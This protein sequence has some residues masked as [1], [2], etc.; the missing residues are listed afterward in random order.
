MKYANEQMSNEPMT[1]I[2]YPISGPQSSAVTVERAAYVAIGLLAAALRFFQLGVRPLNGAEAVQALAALHFTQG[3]SASVPTGTIPALFSGNVVGFTL[4]GADD[5][6]ARLLPA[7]AGLVLVLL[8]YSLRGR[9]GRGGALAASLLL[10]VSPSAVYLSRCLDGAILVA[11][12]GLAL[13]VGLINFLDT[14]RPA[15]FY[16][17]AGAL[18]LGLCAGPAFYTLVLTFVAFVP[19]LYLAEKLLDGESGWPALL[20]AW[21]AI[22]EEKGLLATAAA[23]AAAAFGL[24]ATTFILHPAGVGQAA[25]LLGAWAQSF[26]PEPGGQPA[27]YLLLLLLL[28]EPLIL[29]LGAVEAG[30]AVVARRSPQWPGQTA[31][32]SFP[33]TAFFAFWGGL[34]FLVILVSGH[35]PAGNVLLVVVPLALLAGQGAERAWRWIDRRALWPEVGA[36]AA[37]A[38]G[39][40]IFFYLQIASYSLTP[41]AATVTYGGITFYTSTT[42]LLLASLALALLVVLG[43]VA[44]AWRG[45]VLVA[46]GGWLALVF[47]LLLVAFKATWGLNMAHAADPRELMIARGTAADVRTLVSA[48]ETLSTDQ[49]SDAHTLPITVDAATGPV[50]AWYLRDFQKQTVVED[51]STPPATVAALTL[52]RRD[53]PIGETY[54]G[55]GF[56]LSVHWSPW[57]LWGQKL[58]CWLL[59]TKGYEPV[60][61]TEVVLWVASEP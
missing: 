36:I 24:V 61:D 56:P 60:V 51:L 45:R 5:V 8:P 23:I 20:E 27:L 10:A 18:G 6:I 54:R 59:F 48:L 49:T 43:V 3:A 13:A 25:D 1:N 17:A 4:L 32:S 11:A 26:L 39:T 29:F 53:L 21:W 19:L 40:G 55:Q 34:A 37:V 58:T 38:L 52:A 9:L 47:I 44:W 14:R 41:N 35:R 30:R 12:C 50:V 42:Y 28:Y 7:L 2:Q 33:H 16:L 31:G 46:G 22:R 15:W 57:G